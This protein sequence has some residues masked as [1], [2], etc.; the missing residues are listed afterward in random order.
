MSPAQPWYR[1]PWPWILMSGPAAVVVAGSITAWMA[2][3]SAD[4]LVADDYYKRGLAINAVLKRE[5]E[6][7]RRGITAR[8]ERE[9]DGIAV[10]LRGAAPEALILRLAHATR[11]GNDLRL[12]LAR[13]ADGAYRAALPPLAAGRWRAVV[14]DARGEWRVVQEDL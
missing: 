1:E 12:R 14:D 8:V 13:G 6:A 10:R 2:F 9:R 3:A 5:Q 4:G 11:A 7:A